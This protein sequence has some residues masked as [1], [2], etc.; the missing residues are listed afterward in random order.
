MNL[1]AHYK[2]NQ[3]IASS[4]FNSILS[5]R[6]QIMKKLITYNN[7]LKFKKEVHYSSRFIVLSEG[8]F[9]RRTHSPVVS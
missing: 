5:K 2:Y 9:H 4:N 6:T 8:N 7:S 1:Q 3:S